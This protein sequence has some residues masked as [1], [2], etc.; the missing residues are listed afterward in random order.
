MLRG[1]LRLHKK[2]SYPIACT[3]MAAAGIVHEYLYMICVYQLAALYFL[4]KDSAKLNIVKLRLQ[5]I[6]C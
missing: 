3:P 6:C 4:H 5:L 1:L 2:L